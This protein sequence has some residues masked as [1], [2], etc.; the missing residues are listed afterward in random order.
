MGRLKIN[1]S[2]L[3]KQ[4]FDKIIKPS[5]RH[6]NDAGMEAMKIVREKSVK[7]WYGKNGL[8]SWGKAMNEATFYRS[9]TEFKSN[10]IVVTV[11]SKI[12]IGKYKS[13]KGNDLRGINR[14]RDRHE[15]D[16][17]TF[18]KKDGTRSEPQPAVEMPIETTAEYLINLKWNKG[19]VKLP[20]KSSIGTDWV[21]KDFKQDEPLK[22]VVA[23]NIK[24]DWEKTVN[25]IVK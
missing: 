23:K 20:K 10:K 1:Q 24:T 15:E 16:G 9:K 8:R 12:D 11:E 3:E 25:E 14:W 7:K 19:I 13:L 2:E 21:N 4:I 17:W 18:L 22:D 5:V 6:W